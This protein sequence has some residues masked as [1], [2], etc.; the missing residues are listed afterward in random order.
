MLMFR[1]L[2]DEILPI[3]EGVNI[4]IPGDESATARNLQNVINTQLNLEGFTVNEAK[5][6]YDVVEVR[7]SK[8]GLVKSFDLNGI[9]INTQENYMFDVYDISSTYANKDQVILQIAEKRKSKAEGDKA[10]KERREQRY[11]KKRTLAQIMKEDNL[12]RTEATKIFKN[13]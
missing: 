5:P 3:S 10:A 7:D 6:G 13:Q 9:D 2:K 8:G 11:G 4:F 1:I 12:S